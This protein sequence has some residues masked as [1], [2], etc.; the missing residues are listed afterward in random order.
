MTG[1]GIPQLYVVRADGEQIYG[2]AGALSGDDL[3]TMLMASLKRSGRAFTN[4]EADFLNRTVRASELALQA[5]DLLKTGVILSEVGKLGPH[6]NLGSFAEPAIKSK[7]LYMELKKQIDSR[8]AKAKVDL[9]DSNAAEPLDTLLTVYEGE[10]VAKL[11]PKW[12]G[13]ASSITRAIKKQ[14]QYS[15]AAEQ[16]ELL[17]RARVVAA[18]L[19]P[20]IRNRAESI[21]TSA[22]RRFPNTEADTIARAELAKVAPDSKI[23]NMQSVAPAA[24]PPQA[25]KFRTWAT[26]KGDFKTQAKYVR[27]KAGKVQLMKQDGET[28]VVEIAILSSND[29]K[30]ISERIRNSD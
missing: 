11:F 14:T 15:I 29:Q 7:E 5:G 28:I 16:A 10:A 17:V 18:S 27:Q 25:S 12:K 13:T 30:Y 9:L 3:P 26:Q 6:E 21:Y 4:Q 2:G 24:G 20:R 19:T 8:M 23:L 1:N 22:I